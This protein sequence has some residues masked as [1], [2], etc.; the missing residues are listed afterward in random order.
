MLFTA[1]SSHLVKMMTVRLTETSVFLSCVCSALFSGEGMFHVLL[2]ESAG[3]LMSSCTS[4]LGS[5]CRRAAYGGSGAKPT[6]RG[7]FRGPPARSD[8]Q[9][10]K[11]SCVGASS[12]SRPS[13][14]TSCHAVARRRTRVHTAST[15]SSP[16]LTLFPPNVHI[17]FSFLTTEQQRRMHGGL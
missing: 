15:P 4:T 14:C 7:Y 1:F 5:V 6:R 2:G 12:G 3:E 11:P 8:R 13:P 16:L 9:A 17:W 10:F